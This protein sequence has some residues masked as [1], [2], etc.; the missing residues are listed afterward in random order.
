MRPFIISSFELMDVCLFKFLYLNKV[1]CALTLLISLEHK[2]YFTFNIC[3]IHENLLVQ[4]T[5]THGT[6]QPPTGG[7]PYRV[8]QCIQ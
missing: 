5:L 6:D 3:L 4:Y 7:S 8:A 1:V 2:L